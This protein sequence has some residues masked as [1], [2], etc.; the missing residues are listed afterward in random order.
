MPRLPPCCEPFGPIRTRRQ[1]LA[2]AGAW[3]PL[4]AQ[5][6]PTSLAGAGL[7]RNQITVGQVLSLEGGRNEHGVAV[8]QGV[9]AALQVINALL[10]KPLRPARRRALLESMLAPPAVG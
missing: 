3:L 2:L 7:S 9:E 4:A 6:Q 8:R 10:A 5:A 1:L